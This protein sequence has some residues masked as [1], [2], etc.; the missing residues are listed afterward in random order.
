M[1]CD[2]VLLSGATRLMTWSCRSRP[3]SSVSNCCRRLVFLSVALPTGY[4][5]YPG[6]VFSSAVL[7]GAE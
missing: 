4:K 2:S 5:V 6:L 1:G 3:E 7:D